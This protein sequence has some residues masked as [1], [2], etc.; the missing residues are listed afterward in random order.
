MARWLF[1]EIVQ[2]RTWRFWMHGNQIALWISLNMIVHTHKQL[3]ACSLSISAIDSIQATFK[4][5][6]GFVDFSQ[7]T[8]SC[9]PKYATLAE[10]TGFSHRTLMRHI[11]ELESLG[12]ITKR[13]RG[14]IDKKTGQRRQTSNLYTFNMV[15]IKAMIAR[16]M[17][18][19]AGKVKSTAKILLGRLTPENIACHPHVSPVTTL[20]HINHKHLSSKLNDFV[21]SE[22]PKSSESSKPEK[23]MMIPNESPT[24]LLARMSQLRR[25]TSI[26]NALD[27]RGNQWFDI[28][29]GLMFKH[30]VYAHDQRNAVGY[31]AEGSSQIIIEGIK[32][33][34]QSLLRKDFRQ[35]VLH[36]KWW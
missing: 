18:K 7:G 21:Q 10:I 13:G 12:V 25:Y 30:S 1:S 2:P 29:S 32:D 24:D 31:V 26:Q 33:W 5:L 34:A 19:L 20:E 6:A 23:K 9:F 16:K 15:V 28:K 14:Y 36:E 11:K 27:N 3:Q 8:L 17:A 35:S 22:Q 4:A